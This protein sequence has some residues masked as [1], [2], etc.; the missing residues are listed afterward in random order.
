MLVS[1]RR[2]LGAVTPQSVTMRSIL[3]L[4]AGS[5]SVALGLVFLPLPTPFGV[6]LFLVGAGLILMASPMARALFKRW[7]TSHKAASDTLRRI[8]AYL[9]RPL[10]RALRQTHPEP[11]DPEPRHP[12][13]DPPRSETG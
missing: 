7:R 8:E 5:T 11:G 1:S 6:P 2:L 10:R 13:T 12:S 4:L 9:P 3:L